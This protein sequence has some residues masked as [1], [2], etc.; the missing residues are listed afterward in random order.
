MGK[1]DLISIREIADD[2]TT[3]SSTRWAFA[4]VV[5]ADLYIVVITIL[6]G[7]V[8]HFL[9]KPIPNEFYAS[10]ALLL[11]VITGIIGGN[12]ALQGFETKKNDKPSIANTEPKKEEDEGK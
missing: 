1:K 6:S 12:K 9:G 11:G 3:I 8:G 5:K 10:V 7:I 4:S 2:D